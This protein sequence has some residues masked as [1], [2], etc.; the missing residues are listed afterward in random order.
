MVLVQ[1]YLPDRLDEPRERIQNQDGYE[2]KS[3]SKLDGLPGGLR[4]RETPVAYQNVCFRVGVQVGNL[5]SYRLKVGSCWLTFVRC[6]PTIGLLLLMYVSNRADA[7]ESPSLRFAGGIKLLVGRR[8]ERQ[9]RVTWIRCA[10][11]GWDGMF[12]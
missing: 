7:L 6:T 5:I 1:N 10:C 11:G 2:T 8:T 12:R 4:F 3:G 9:S